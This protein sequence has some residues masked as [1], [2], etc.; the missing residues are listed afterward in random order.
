LGTEY[1]SEGQSMSWYPRFSQ[2]PLFLLI[3]REK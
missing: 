2:N 3:T 1:L